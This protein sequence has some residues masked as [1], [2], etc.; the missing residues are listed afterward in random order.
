M[1]VTVLGMGMF[2]SA[3]F[4]AMCW[5]VG[6]LD[7]CEGV[8]GCLKFYLAAPGASLLAILV[9]LLLH[10]QISR[11]VRVGILV[12]VIGI[13]VLALTVLHF[14]GSD[15]PGLLAMV[16][17]G[18]V[19]DGIFLRRQGPARMPVAAA[20][21]AGWTTLIIA[22]LSTHSLGLAEVNRFGLVAGPPGEV[23][24]HTYEEQIKQGV[25]DPDYP[26]CR[27]E[28]NSLGYRDLE[29][30]M[31]P[32]QRRR[33]LLVGDSFVWGD[34][35]PTLD[36]TI[37]ANL[38]RELEERAP[39]R[40]EVMA[41]GWPGNGLWGYRRTA[42]VL[43]PV[44]RPSV[45]IVLCLGEPDFVP[46]DPQ[47]INDSLPVWV[48]ARNLFENLGMVRRVEHAAQGHRLSFGASVDQ[49]FVTESLFGLLQEVRSSD[50]RL[51]LLDF[52]RG[53]CRSSAL[54]SLYQVEVPEDLTYPGSASDLWYGWDSHP[55]PALNRLISRVLADRL[56]AIE[57]L[58]TKP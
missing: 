37:G 9:L 57:A 53:M 5:F 12:P 10:V 23:R 33:I 40:Y 56:Q 55:K 58:S 43:A 41:A 17:G 3:E 14:T 28:Y 25:K 26:T 4:A 22:L 42:A 21:A 45:V 20:L 54:E 31:G 39:G 15:A 11:R 18:V 51:V 44:W 13:P 35:I 46:I 24:V 38:R 30:D 52:S 49:E 48:P 29:P 1:L 16:A 19:M 50:A 7:A 6:T 27:F 32:S 34:G 36:G 2:L 47:R 8:C